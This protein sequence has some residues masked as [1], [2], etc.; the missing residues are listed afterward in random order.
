MRDVRE[1]GLDAAVAPTLY[2]PYA[3]AVPP[4]EDPS[5]SFFVVVRT[6]TDA[7]AYRQPIEAVVHRLDPDLPIADVRTLDGRVAESLA[8]RRFAML[9]LGAFAG[10]TLILVV[11]GM[12]GVMSYLVTQRRR[13][14]GVRIALGATPRDLL[15]L[16][17]SQGL[18]VTAIGIPVGLLTADILSQFAAGQ[19]FEV[20]LLDPRIYGATALVMAAVAVAACAPPALSAA[21]RSDHDAAAGMRTSWLYRACEPP[22]SVSHSKQL[23]NV[24]YRVAQSLR[25]LSAQL[26][27][28]GLCH[29]G[30]RPISRSLPGAV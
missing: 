12:Y 3:P 22:T 13:E 23:A 8:R 20:K 7:L 10:V 14:F 11:A 15:A 19:L 4:N 26:C 9:L 25:S 16:V 24:L 18:Q 1:R 21:A 17:L 30:R 28:L 5:G 2:V 6:A 27:H 29:P